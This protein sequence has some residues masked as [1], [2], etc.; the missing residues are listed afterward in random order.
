MFNWVI[1]DASCYLRN[2]QL[3]PSPPPPPNLWFISRV[4]CSS[5]YIHD[6]HEDWNVPCISYSP[7]C[8]NDHL[9]YFIWWYTPCSIYIHDAYVDWNIHWISYGPK[10]YY[11]CLWDFIW[12]Y[13][14]FSIKNNFMKKNLSCLLT[15]MNLT[16]CISGWWFHHWFV[17]RNEWMFNEG[18]KC[19]I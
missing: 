14:P 11:G 6:V 5:I 1:K 15:G 10:C 12:L 9:W 17:A 4:R 16:N 13:A 3:N 18:R 7:N 2:E 19:Y 8:F